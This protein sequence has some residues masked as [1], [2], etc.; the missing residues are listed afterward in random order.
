MS[1]V[2]FVYF[3]FF[4]ILFLVFVRL[5]W[6][7]ILIIG[8][9]LYVL[10]MVALLSLV[11]AVFWSVFI[12]QTSDGWLWIWAYCFLAIFSIGVVYV[13]IV[14]DIYYLAVDWIKSVFGGRG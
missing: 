7:E 6:K 8:Y 1:A 5:F 10:G 14:L 13:L 3:S 11:M 12:N 9:V 2:Q 4:T